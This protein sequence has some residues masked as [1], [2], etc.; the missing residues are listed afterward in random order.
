MIYDTN[1]YPILNTPV[2]KSNV[3]IT[4]NDED[5]YKVAISSF[6]DD[7]PIKHSRDCGVDFSCPNIMPTPCNDCSVSGWN[8]S[9]TLKR[10]KKESI[11]K[12]RNAK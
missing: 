5:L 8:A 4:L 12:L 11:R 6:R 3:N 9:M 2:Y 10:I 7:C 1:G